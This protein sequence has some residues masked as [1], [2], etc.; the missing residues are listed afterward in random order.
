[1]T[2]GA[3]RWRTRCSSVARTMRCTSSWRTA[4]TSSDD[5]PGARLDDLYE[6]CGQATKSYKARADIEL[7]LRKLLRSGSARATV[8]IGS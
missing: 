1:M 2:T 5:K 8:G 7:I 6:V 3:V 4:S